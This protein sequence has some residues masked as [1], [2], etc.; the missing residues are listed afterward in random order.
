MGRLVSLSTIIIEGN[1]ITADGLSNAM[2][3][4]DTL[5]SRLPESLAF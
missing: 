3:S 4:E 2:F 5:R 1:V